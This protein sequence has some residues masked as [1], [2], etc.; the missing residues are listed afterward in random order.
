MG[1]GWRWC[2]RAKDPSSGRCACRSTASTREVGLGSAA[3]AYAVGLADARDRAFLIHKHLREGVPLDEAVRR[4]TNRSMAARARPAHG[5][6]GE[7]SRRWPRPT[8]SQHEPS[9]KSAVHT[10]QWWSTLEM[11]AYRVIGQKSP[12]DVTTAEVIAILKRE[13]RQDDLGRSRRPRAG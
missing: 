13:S 8:S 10:R 6:Q 12:G 5:G 1:P 3:G 9:W 11:Y 7:R 4:V 2:A